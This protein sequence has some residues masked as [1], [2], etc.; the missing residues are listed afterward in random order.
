RLDRPGQVSLTEGAVCID[1]ANLLV[2]APDR[3]VTLAAGRC[4]VRT[5]G[6][7]SGVF[8]ASGV[9]AIVSSQPAPARG[10]LAGLMTGYE[11]APGKWEATPAPRAAARL[12]WIRDLVSEG[13]TPLVPASSYGGGALV[14]VDANGQEARLS[15]RKYHIDVHI[16]D[17]FA[18]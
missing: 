5:D 17:G 4:E 14:A 3:G 6:H 10:Q 7:A 2:Q 8:V 16:E 15:L 9:A 18:R 12:D 13:E 11:L 1:G